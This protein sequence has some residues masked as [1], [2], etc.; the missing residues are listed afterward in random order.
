MAAEPA[1][2][3]TSPVIDETDA[4]IQE[5][6]G[7]VTPEAGVWLG[8]PAPR[9]DRTGVGLYLLELT[10]APPPRGGGPA[11]LQIKLRYLL[12]T[13]AASPADEHRLLGQLVF[14]ALQR[15]GWEV[16]LGLIPASLWQAFGVA[17]RPAFRLLVP[18]R[19]ERPVRR[20]PRVRSPAV[21]QMAPSEPLAGRVLGP[22]DVP[23]AAAR[24]EL[25]GLD[26]SVGTDPDGYFL[27]SRVP[28][29]PRAKR[30]RVRARGDVQDFQA[31]APPAGG[32]L[33]IIRFNLQEG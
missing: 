14:A 5:W 3:E 10:E 22:G 29:E 16:D 2:R 13:W 28:S 18:L 12:T 24:V 31:E 11:P 21:I 23:L 7:Q 19:L 30:F 20:A 4:R 8:P 26:I 1:A 27:F 15:D 32:G 9:Q 6:I 25:P 17:P 33:V